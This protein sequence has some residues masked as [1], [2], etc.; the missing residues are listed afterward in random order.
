[1]KIVT[2]I[3]I[4]LLIVILIA[5]GIIF[6]SV[7]YTLGREHEPY[8]DLIEKYSQELDIDEELL[9]AFIKVESRFDPEAKSH[10]GAIGLMQLLPDTAEWM[11]GKLD[12]DYKEEDLLDPEANIRLG[13]NY[14]KYLF[15]K[16][17]SE[18]LAILAYNGG[19][20]NVDQWLE[21]GIITNNQASYKDVPIYETRTY[22]TRIKD[23]RDLYK[24]VWKDVLKKKDDSQFV[25]T[26]KFIKILIGNY[27]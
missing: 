19:P 25:R 26:F 11:A 12:I 4:F 7:Y 17:K 3:I 13:T 5:T 8:I 2:K 20:G 6:A 10:A 27:I 14:Y 18:D 23:N 22:L 9:A 15:N 24:L 16:Y 1:M 21:N